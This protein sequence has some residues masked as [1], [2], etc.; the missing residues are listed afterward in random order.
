MAH[1]YASHCHCAERVA[2]LTPSSYWQS[3]RMQRHQSV[4]LR[5]DRQGCRELVRARMHANQL[6][7]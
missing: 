7:I 3:A 4:G 1:V 5:M 6:M 2:L